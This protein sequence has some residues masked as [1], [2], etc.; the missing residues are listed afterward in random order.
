MGCKLDNASE[1]ITVRVEDNEMEQ[2]QQFKKL[3]N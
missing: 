2:V 1:Q 3:T